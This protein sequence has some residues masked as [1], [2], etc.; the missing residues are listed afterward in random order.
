VFAAIVAYPA[1]EAHRLASVVIGIGI[2]SW[3]ILFGSLVARWSF[4]VAWALFAFGAEYAL[5]LRLRGG[6]VDTRA[7]FIAGAVVLVAELAFRSIIPVHG[8]PDA[9]VVLRSLVAIVAA[10]ALAMVVAGVV[11]VAAG[12]VSSGIAFEAFGVLSAALAIGL[13]LR[14]A[15]RSKLSRAA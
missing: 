11:L 13:V 9:R 3:V 4:G 15:T 1:A 8:V 14:V 10:L 7:L 12:S 6:A 5:F 2:A